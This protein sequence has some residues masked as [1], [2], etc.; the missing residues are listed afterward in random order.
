MLFEH[1]YGFLAET[2]PGENVILSYEQMK[3]F[4]AITSNAIRLLGNA[5]SLLSKERRKAQQNQFQGHAVISCL[6]RVSSSW[7][8]FVWGRI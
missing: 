7:Q 8:K 6:R 5:S 3:E 4:G 2:K 1:V